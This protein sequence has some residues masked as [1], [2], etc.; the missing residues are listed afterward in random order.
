MEEERDRWEVGA[1]DPRWEQ[2]T[3][4]RSRRKSFGARP[5]RGG[6]PLEGGRGQREERKK[7]LWVQ[8]L[9][10]DD[11]FWYK[12]AQHNSTI[13]ALIV[14]GGAGHRPQL[15]RKSIFVVVSIL[16]DVKTFFILFCF[17]LYH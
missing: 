4:G 16:V 1:G 17:E 8:G 9:M 14:I 3:P 7:K 11:L 15:R 6:R 10:G 2:D 13:R 12:T 5:G